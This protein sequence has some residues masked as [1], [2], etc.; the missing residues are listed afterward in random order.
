[1]DE[2][3]RSGTETSMDKNDFGPETMKAIQSLQQTSPR[4]PIGDC[5]GAYGTGHPYQGMRA[6]PNKGPTT[7][8]DY[9]R[10][11][12]ERTKRIE[13]ALGL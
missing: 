12:N 9:I 1:M 13:K 2:Q 5:S 6:N 3:P 8:A 7:L 4:L 11:I 10:E